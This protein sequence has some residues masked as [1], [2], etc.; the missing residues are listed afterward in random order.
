L[1][2]RSWVGARGAHEGAHDAHSEAGFAGATVTD[3]LQ[4]AAIT[5]RYGADEAVLLALEAGEDILLFANQQ[6]YDAGIVQRVVG[7]VLGAVARGRLTAEQIGRKWQ[8]RAALLAV[9][10]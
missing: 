2:A 1:P 4:A 8:R 9:T 3:D 5:Q 10:G 6:V 7:V